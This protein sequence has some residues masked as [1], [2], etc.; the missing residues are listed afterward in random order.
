MKTI[1]PSAVSLFP[2]V[3]W[4]IGNHAD[5]LTPWIPVIAMRSSFRTNF[6]LLPCCSYDFSG[7][8]YVRKDTSKSQ[9]SDYLAYIEEICKLCGFETKVDKLRIPSTKKICIVSFG[10]TYDADRYEIIN[11]NITKFIED[12]TGSVNKANNE[13]IGNFKPRNNVEKV[14]NCTQLDRDLISRILLQVVKRLLEDTCTT[15]GDDGKL[16]NRGGTLPFSLLISSIRKEDLKKLKDNCGGLQTLLRNHRYIFEVNK[17]LVRIRVPK[18]LNETNKY[19]DKLCYFFR[20]HPGGCP[21][22]AETCAYKH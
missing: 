18:T 4:I 2:D 12:K 11:D 7:D 9:Y 22:F 15:V 10:R 5:E 21:N 19:K 1:V 8:K 3:D 16:W 17:G 13:W 20:N 14:K 6:F